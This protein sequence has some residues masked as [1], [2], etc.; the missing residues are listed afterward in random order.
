MASKKS[1]SN[2]KN[3]RM[4]YPSK[5]SQ[6]S[7]KGTRALRAIRDSLRP[8]LRR[9]NEIVSQ[10]T[11]E[12]LDTESY[13]ISEAQRT[14]SRAKGVNENELFSIDDKLRYRDLV[15]EANRLEA[16]LSNP[17][18]SPRVVEYNRTYGTRIS[19]QD[20]KEVFEATGNR[21]DVDDQDRMKLALRIFR[22]I[23]STETSVI[24]S[25]AYGSDNLINLIYDEL[26]GYSIY[27]TDDENDD[28]NARVHDIAYMAIE[29]YKVNTMWGFLEGTPAIERDVNIVQEL[30]K[31]MTTDE[32]F[33]RN[34]FLRTW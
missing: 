31:S 9:A 23:A 24:G 4:K 30:R 10:L 26:E 3:T 20:Q 11:K 1:R 12:G 27:N 2:S 34:P 8:L 32:F 16:F 14:K 6:G 29:N 19:F 21:F 18:I 15:R 28:I 33:K 17:E 7:K 13:A 5:A 25:N 22:D